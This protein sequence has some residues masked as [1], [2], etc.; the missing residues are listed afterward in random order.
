MSIIH[1]LTLLALILLAL[2][3]HDEIKQRRAD[4]RRKEHTTD[5]IA[6]LSMLSAQLSAGIT[7]LAAL[8]QI[9]PTTEPGHAVA[10]LQHELQWYGT[11]QV[12]AQVKAYADPIARRMRQLWQVANHH[13]IA[14]AQL[15][16]QLEHT[17]ATR[18]S[19]AHQLWAALA[20]PRAS[21][22]ILMGLPVVGIVLGEH[23]GAHSLR[24]LTHTTA[25]G[26]LSLIGAVLIVVGR[27]W[28]LA[29]FYRA[30]ARLAP[31]PTRQSRPNRILR[32]RRRLPR[33]VRV[34]SSHSASGDVATCIQTSEDLALLATALRSGLPLADAADV[35]ADYE[36]GAGSAHESS[37]AGRWR[38][39]SRYLRCGEYDRAHQVWEGAPQLQ[40]WWRRIEGCVSSGIGLAQQTSDFSLDLQCSARRQLTATAEQTGVFIAG[41]LSLCFLP[42]FIAVG[43]IPIAFGLF[44]R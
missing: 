41:P 6:V 30:T 20:G 2:Q 18:H 8:A 10:Q 25:G 7:P 15:L 37:A 4:R 39:L 38:A 3:V 36:D 29:L 5:W 23:L 40:Q 19:F 12:E 32:Y 13:G 9:S 14:L 33:F 16:G 42:A 44:G 31:T 1:P 28:S 11:V 35:V 17:V 22:T 21:A 26:I 43:L 34:T 24:L 27:R